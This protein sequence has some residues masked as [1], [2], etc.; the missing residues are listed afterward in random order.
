MEAS[1]DRVEK[2][3]YFDPQGGVEW[4]IK[5]VSQDMV[6]LDLMLKEIHTGNLSAQL[7]YGGADPQSPSTSIRVG[8]T[9]SDR[10]LLGSGIQCKSLGNLFK[11]RCPPR[12]RKLFS[13]LDL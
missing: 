4:R 3:G 10:N 5:K 9:A 7:S 11:A 1:K 8:F 2:L 6:D 13:T 12:N